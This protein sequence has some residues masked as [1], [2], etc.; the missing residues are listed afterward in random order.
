MIQTKVNCEIA[1][2]TLQLC[3]DQNVRRVCQA[4]Q[5]PAWQT[6]S[7][8]QRDNQT[9]DG[10]RII[11][12]PV[13]AFS[14]RFQGHVVFATVCDSSCQAVPCHARCIAAIADQWGV[15]PFKRRFKQCLACWVDAVES[16]GQVARRQQQALQG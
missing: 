13:S 15:L 3:P 6:C 8:V 2:R 14:Y 16:K 5:R 12:R 11:M 4:G 10:T 1:L 7:A 9:A